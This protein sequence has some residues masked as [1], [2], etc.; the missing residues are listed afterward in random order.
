MAMRGLTVFITDLRAC[1][2]REEEEKRINKEIANIRSKF[3]EGKLTSYDK[4]KY[5][6]KMLYMYILGWEIDFGHA[7]AVAL[8]SGTKYTEKQIGYL[9]VTTFLSEN[10]EL[11]RLVVNSMKNDLTSA[12]DVHNCLALTAIANIGGREIAEALHQDVLRL[13]VSGSSNSFVK[14]KAALCLLRLYRKNPEVISAPDWA[15]RIV[16]LLDENDVG[17]LTAVLSL[18]IAL[19]QDFPK[20]MVGSVGKVSR[21]LSKLVE[22]SFSPDYDYYGVSSPWL[23]VK[24]LRLLQFY[25]PAEYSSQLSEINSVLNKMMNRFHENTKPGNQSNSINSIIVEAINLAIHINPESAECSLATTIL[26]A[27]ISHK[28]SNLRYLGL[29]TMANLAL[30]KE[31]LDSIKRHTDQILAALRDRDISVRRRGKIGR[32]HV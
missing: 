5:V 7:E 27:F 18:L 12:I 23:Q 8:I 28:E 3:K 14:K 15:P 4:K 19:A 2:S 32:A 30:A 13:L 29:E 22:K 1:R 20:E 9:A 16:N 25:S 17:V 21:I 11:I 24:C 10:S 6:C 31:S 26:G